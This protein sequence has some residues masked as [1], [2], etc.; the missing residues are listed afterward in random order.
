[1]EAS[2]GAEVRRP[3]AGLRASGAEVVGEKRPAAG[4]KRPATKWRVSGMGAR[5]GVYFSS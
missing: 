2:R 1:M 4:T 5:L 3:A